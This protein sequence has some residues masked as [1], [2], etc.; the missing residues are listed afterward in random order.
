M[1]R[2]PAKETKD[3]ARLRRTLFIPR[4][5]ETLSYFKCLHTELLHS[6]HFVVNTGVRAQTKPY[7]NEMV[8]IICI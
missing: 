4:L 2:I 8:K 6:S 5:T 7:R 3:V 1:H